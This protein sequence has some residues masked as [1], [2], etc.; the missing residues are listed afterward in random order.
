[1]EYAT[2]Q[3]LIW[4]SFTGCSSLQCRKVVLWNPYINIPV[5]LVVFLTITWKSVPQCDGI[6]IPLSYASRI[7]FKYFYSKYIRQKVGIVNVFCLFSR[8]RWANPYSKLIVDKYNINKEPE[9]NRIT[10]GRGAG[11][12]AKASLTGNAPHRSEH[13]FIQSTRGWCGC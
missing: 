4:N 6:S 10:N 8:S 3:C 1:M 9:N 13:A 7:S 12:R 5:L 11:F 2:N